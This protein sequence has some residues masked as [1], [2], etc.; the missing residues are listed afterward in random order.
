MLAASG[1]LFVIQSQFGLVGALDGVP[2]RA[3]ASLPVGFSCLQL[4]PLV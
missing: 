2:I 3:Y 4:L 1:D